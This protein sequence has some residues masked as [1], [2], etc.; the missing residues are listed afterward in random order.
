MAEGQQRRRH[1]A[2]L[3]PPLLLLAL[4]LRLPQLVLVPL[5]V[6]LVLVVMMPLLVLLPLHS[7]ACDKGS[8]GSSKCKC[9]EQRKRSHWRRAQAH[10]AAAMSLV[11]PLATAL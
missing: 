10:L 8:N 5:L 3:A 1:I 2:S 6:L 11:A 7:N 4:L 9:G